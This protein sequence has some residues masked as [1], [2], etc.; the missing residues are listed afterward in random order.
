MSRLFAVALAV[1]ALFATAPGSGAAGR[2]VFTFASIDGGQIDLGAYAGRPVLVVN[3]A[4]RCGYVGQ[5]DDLQAIYDHYRDKGLVVLAVPSNDFKQE[6]ASNDQVASF[7]AVNF[8]LD[9][10]MTE[11]T[12]VTGR[13]AHPFYRWLAETEGVR[14]RWNFTKVLIGPAGQFVDAWGPSVRPT[15]AA[16]TDRIEAL[17]N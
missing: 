6:L 13:T 1:F 4:S 9:L 14:P 2:M 16:I 3:T 17:L 8:D 7:C 15:A 10:P 11:I 12:P 5:F